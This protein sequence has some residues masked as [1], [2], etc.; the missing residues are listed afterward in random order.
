MHSALGISTHLGWAAVSALLLDGAT[1]R[2]VRT[3]RLA[4]ADPADAEAVE[5]YHAAAGYHAGLR[6][7]QPEEPEHIVRDALRRQ[8]RYTEIQLGRL[9]RA[10]RDWPSPVQAALFVGRGRPA[11]SLE[12][13]LASHAQI[14]VAE[15][16]AVRDAVRHAL[17][18][19]QIST[20]PLDRHALPERV[21]ELIDLEAPAA[22][23]LLRGLTPDNGGIWRRE[24]RDCALAAWLAGAAALAA[25]DFG[26]SP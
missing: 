4:T 1:P 8:R 21:T 22:E 25:Q 9:L 13:V 7:R 19:R 3:F 2:Q 14:H 20:L 17:E 24:Q 16:N 6:A 23:Q 12:R 5:P 26:F 11:A 15:G 18:R 10:L